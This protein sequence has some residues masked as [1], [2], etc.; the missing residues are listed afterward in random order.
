[1]QSKQKN[2]KVTLTIV[3]LLLFIGL[4]LSSG[5]KEPP[6]PTPWTPTPSSTPTCAPRLTLATPSEWGK[7]RIVV[8]LYDPRVVN[9]DDSPLLI[10]EQKVS[11]VDFLKNIV[12]QI[13]E[14]KDQIAIFQLGYA[15]YDDALVYKDR[16]FIIPPQMLNTPIPRSTL[17]PIPTL[18]SMEPGLNAVA[19]SNAATHTASKYFAT[20]TAIVQENACDRAF[21]NTQI[22]P[23]ATAWLAT[24]TSEIGSMTQDFLDAID[25]YYENTEDRAQPFTTDELYYGGVYDGLN[26]ASMV[27]GSNCEQNK[28]TLIIIDDFST[29]NDYNKWKEN[30]SE[31]NPNTPIN[32]DLSG[33]DIIGIVPQCKDIDSPSCQKIIN[34]WEEEFKNFGDISTPIFETGK[35]ADIT[36]LQ[37]FRR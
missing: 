6:S 30:K 2:K 7:S 4:A 29:W 31:F 35:R 14:P 23:T 11:V 17:T 9:T 19:T 34:P 16:S 10:N 15:S 3:L 8:I 28:C 21:W 27:F 18:P 22:P 24:A 13:I 25:A 37:Y 20:Q 1:M 33:V 26:F 5:C 12:P 36:I 32:I